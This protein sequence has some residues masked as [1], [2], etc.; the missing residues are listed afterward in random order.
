M[1]LL[2]VGIIVA[3]FLVGVVVFIAFALLR[4][5]ARQEYALIRR[6]DDLELAVEELVD[7]QSS[8]G[9]GQAAEGVPLGTPAPT[10]SLPALTGS[11]RTVALEEFHGRR[12]VLLFIRPGCSYCQQMA[13][14]LA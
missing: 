2:A 7:A 10:F 4:Q 12:L 5:A 1:E 14:D 8:R 13:P 11:P 9:G 3:W 6:L